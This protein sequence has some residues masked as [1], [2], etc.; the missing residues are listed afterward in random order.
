MFNL[1]CIFYRLLIN[2][3]L[4]FF[5]LYFHSFQRFSTSQKSQLIIFYR[6]KEL[7]KLPT[8]KRASTN[9]DFVSVPDGVALFLNGTACVPITITILNDSLPELRETFQVA[10]TDAVALSNTFQRSL[11]KPNLS[12][13]GSVVNITIE[14]NDSP[15]GLFVLSTDLTFEMSRKIMVNEPEQNLSRKVFIERTKGMPMNVT[16]MVTFY[17]FDFLFLLL[18]IK[19]MSCS[20]FF[21]IKIL[22]LAVRIDSYSLSAS[23]FAIDL[24]IY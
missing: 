23:S 17:T 22:V 18:S 20:Y 3:S 14:E 4:L 15:Y 12:P 2:L 6:T 16:R 9:N 11:K 7:E 5:Q 13:H 8:E 19:Q 24:N 21:L 1:H 10:L